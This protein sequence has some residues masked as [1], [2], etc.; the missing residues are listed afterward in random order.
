MF[1]GKHRSKIMRKASKIVA[2]VLGVVLCISMTPSVSFAVTN[3]E[4]EEVTLQSMDTSVEINAEVEEY[5]CASESTGRDSAVTCRHN[6]PLKD[7]YTTMR[8]YLYSIPAYDGMDVPCIREW[9]R[10]IICRFE[11]YYLR[12]DI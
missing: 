12:Y 2:V 3:E 1:W 7:P 4:T 9:Y 5:D 8:Q 11:D 10:C 6:D